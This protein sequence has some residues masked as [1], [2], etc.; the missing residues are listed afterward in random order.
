MK[1]NTYAKIFLSKTKKLLPQKLV[2]LNNFIL[3]RCSIAFII[4]NFWLF[5]ITLSALLLLSMP[6]N[7]DPL[8]FKILIF[9]AL[10][11]KEKNTKLYLDM[12]TEEQ[13]FYSDASF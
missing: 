10:F 3:Y 12:T 13:H 11:Y 7:K 2:H 4:R 6:S 5:S 9:N 8:D 1:I